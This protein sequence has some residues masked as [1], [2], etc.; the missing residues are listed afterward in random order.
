MPEAKPLSQRIRDAFIEGNEDVIIGI[1]R[2]ICCNEE[3]FVDTW[4]NLPASMRRAIK[5]LVS[6]DQ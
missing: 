1:Y 2:D 6:D 5:E 4:A 3:L